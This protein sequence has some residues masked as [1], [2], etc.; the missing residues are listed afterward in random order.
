MGRHVFLFACTLL[1]LAASA[2]SATGIVERTFYVKNMTVSRL[3]KTQVITTVNGSL[4]GPT[5]HVQ[6]GDTLVVHVINQ[7]PYNITIHW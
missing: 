7:S 3:C 4:P 5:I 6:E 1:L 2:A